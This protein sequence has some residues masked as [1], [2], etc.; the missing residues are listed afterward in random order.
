MIQEVTDSIKMLYCDPTV[1]EAANTHAHTHNADLSFFF[2]ISDDIF[3]SF[4]LHERLTVACN[5]QIILIK[6]CKH[7]ER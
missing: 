2:Y 1:Q 3:M 7:G 4:Q 6:L 5:L